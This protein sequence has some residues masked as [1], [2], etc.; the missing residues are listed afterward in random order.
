M[1][2]VLYS[3]TFLIILFILAC[4]SV[5]YF[6]RQLINERNLKKEYNNLML[7]IEQLKQENAAISDE[8]EKLKNEE[9]LERLARDLYVLKKPGEKT[10]VVPQEIMQQIKQEKPSPTPTPSFFQKIFLPIQD[11]FRDL[12]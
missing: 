4:L 6:Y 2:K 12:F 9:E 1:P 5:V 3:K 7:K 8:I 10:M 11:F